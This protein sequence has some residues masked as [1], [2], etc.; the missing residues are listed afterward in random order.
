MEIEY[1]GWCPQGRRAED[2]SIPACYALQ[3]TPFS[4]YAQR[5]EWNIRDSD[6]TVIFSVLSLQ[7]EAPS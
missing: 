6:A 1:R 4:D 3:E 7:A 2:G 5:T